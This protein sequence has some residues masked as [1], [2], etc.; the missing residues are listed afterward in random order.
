MRVRGCGLILVLLLFAG[1]PAVVYEDA[2]QPLDD[3]YE[4][5]LQKVGELLERADRLLDV[6]DAQVERME[7]LL[8]WEEE[9]HRRKDALLTRWEEMTERAERQLERWEEQQQ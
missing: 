3:E 7:R 1:C 6:Q 8:E 2:Y 9:Q 4:A 5:Q